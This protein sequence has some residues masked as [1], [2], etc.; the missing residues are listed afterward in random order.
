M[1]YHHDD[2]CDRGAPEGRT[3]F[4][5][6]VR[7]A[8]LG[9]VLASSGLAACASNFP[10]VLKEARGAYEKAES[11]ESAGLAPVELRQAEL[12]LL[13]AEKTF[14]EE[15]DIAETRHKAYIAWRRAQ[16]AEVSGKTRL[17]EK[18]IASAR[19]SEGRVAEEEKKQAFRELD[20]TREELTEA[21][22]READERAKRLQAEAEAGAA[23]ERLR[24]YAELEDTARGIVI[25]LPAGLMFSSGR[26]DILPQARERL[27]EVAKFLQSNPDRR[28]AIEGHTDNQGSDTFNLAL[29]VQRAEAVRQYLE[30][31]GVDRTR[32]SA[33]GRGEQL[34]IG[35]N[36]TA[37]GRAYNRRVEIILEKPTAAPVV[38]PDAEK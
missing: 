10:Q 2:Q 28:V 27:D 19:E 32:M 24:Q 31:K 14:E 1:K 33:A 16:I 21:E 7:A 6:A 9:A 15:G 20:R 37:E 30:Q 4:A 12:A 26:A 35:S 38:E 25:S 11:S 17:N 5:R 8:L 18:R 36:D 29:S 13:D 34:P 23:V 3:F 22:R